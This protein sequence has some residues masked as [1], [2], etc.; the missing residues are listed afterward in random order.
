MRTSYDANP[1]EV[2]YGTL[3]LTTPA[4][5]DPVS[6]ADAKKHLNLDHTDDDAY[7]TDLISVATAHAESYT[8]RQLINATY[9]LQFNAFPD[10]IRLP[11]P[12]A[13]NVT[14]VQYVDGAGTTQTLT[15]NTH[16][17]WVLPSGPFARQAELRPV[18]GTDWPATRNHPPAVIVVYVAGYGASATSVP[19]AIRQ[20]IKAVVATMYEYREEVVTGTIKSEIPEVARRLLYPYRVLAV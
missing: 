2:P 15:Q 19:I 10:V 14:S 6:L 8:N 17:N 1:S 9:T 7:V 16:F 20:A 5:I 3:S 13:S 11:K 18:Y 12:P 4:S